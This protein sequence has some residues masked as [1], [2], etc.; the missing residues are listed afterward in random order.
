MSESILDMEDG[1]RHS[2]ER[3]M[4]TLHVLAESSFF[5]WAIILA[6]STFWHQS[7]ETVVP[8]PYLVRQSVLCEDPSNAHG[9]M[10]SSTSNKPNCT[11]RVASPNGIQKL[12]HRQDCE[13]AHLPAKLV[14]D[15][16]A[17]ADTWFLCSTSAACPSSAFSI[18]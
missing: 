6:L 3:K 13:S 7:I 15:L 18:K 14:A 4:E 11:S 12:P 17:S 16:L 2:Y 10:S 5:T 1:L 9:R 8:R